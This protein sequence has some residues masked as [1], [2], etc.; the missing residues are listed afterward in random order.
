MSKRLLLFLITVMGTTSLLSACQGTETT[1]L[2]QDVNKVLKKPI[3]ITILMQDG[4]NQYAQNLTEDDK[5]FKEM[6]RLFS[7][8]TGTPYNV[9]F[10]MVSSNI[11]DKQLAIR[12]ASGDIP[13]V[14]WSSRIDN[15]S[16]ANAVED[17]VF[18]ELGPL[19]DKYGPN[20][21]KD[22]PAEA[23][24]DPRVSKNGKIYGIPKMS[25]LPNMLVLLYRKDW[26]DK[27]GMKE[28]KTMDDYLAFF[29]AIK[30]L[31]MNGDGNTN[32][33]VP[34]AMRKGLA[35]S[36]AF[37]GYFGAYPDAWQYRDGRFVPNLIVSEMKDAIRFYKMLYDKG[38]INRDMF[39]MK[40]NDWG[41]LIHQGEV[42]MW[43]HQVQVLT[44][45]GQEYL[46][47]DPNATVGVLPGPMN[48]QGKVNLVPER[49]G[50][51][52]VY[53][54][55]S[56][57]AH[58]ED[59]IKFFDWVHSEDP[60]KNKFFAYGIEGINYKVTNGT[61][62]WDP[63]AKVN[64][65]KGTR[66]FYQ[67]MINPGGD[68]RM[69]PLVINAGK[70]AALTQKGIEYTKMNF[71]KDESMYMPTP[72]ILKAKPELGY[73]DGSLYMDMFIKVLTDREPLDDAFDKFVTNWKRQGGE[74]VIQEATNWYK[75]YYKK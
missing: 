16:H 66:V 19:I 59:I 53:T 42:G 13:E 57:A 34:F 46:F 6:S 64:M 9:K 37:F 48:A 56:N 47:T 7:Q 30:N 43:F 5:Y 51:N 61:I 58:P 75:S 31:D 63:N 35:F 20:L 68:A 18:L 10:E 39:T 21:K 49:T 8:Y 14:M 41:D 50:V 67:V 71:F 70:F 23:W 29:D 26:L 60:A 54:I 73:R 32:D 25:A 74:Q 62:N 17:G 15:P 52:N 65:D 55:S 11:Y 3:D 22:I 44:S 1:S 27:L 33:E 28:P 4:G 12:F 36:E 69:S 72:A 45:G 38:Y 24:K 2:K 40:D